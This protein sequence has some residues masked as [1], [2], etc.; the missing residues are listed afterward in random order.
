MGRELRERIYGGIYHVT[1]RGNRKAKI[2]EDDCDR[3]MFLKITME[4]LEIHD[5]RMLGGALLDNHF[6]FDLL[7]PRANLPEFME[8][9]EGRFARF[10]NWRHD[11]VGHLFQGRYRAV[12]I[13]HDPQLFR[14]LAYI[15]LNPV[16]AGA[17]HA[18]EKCAWST[19][20]ATVGLAR[21]PR[22]L[23]SDWLPFLFTGR[24]TSECQQ[25]LQTIMR[26]R[27][28][29]AAYMRHIDGAV[30]ADSGHRPVRSYVHEQRRLALVRLETPRPTLAE[31]YRIHGDQ[32]GHFIWVARIV[33]G[34]KIAEIARAMNLSARFVS[35][36]FRKS[37]HQR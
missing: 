28:P 25:Q 2:F 35:K 20:A 11:R 14:S 33:H 31:L 17:S 22:Y 27:R 1:N 30:L 6:H 12:V 13:E 7:T 3:R 8:Q 10:S 26:E 5:V 32:R 18:P 37:F 19:Y 23:C 4:E 36:V 21:R 15:Y 29:S 24:T 9:V 16:R 34:Y